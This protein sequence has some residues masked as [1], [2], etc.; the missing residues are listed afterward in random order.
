[1]IWA[2]EMTAS[3]NDFFRRLARRYIEKGLEIV[4]KGSDLVP[5]VRA[6]ISSS[7]FESQ[8]LRNAA[9]SLGISGRRN[10]A[11]M[12]EIESNEIWVHGTGTGTGTGRGTQRHL[13]VVG[14][15]NAAG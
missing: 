15:H 4:L 2:R 1:M 12:V 5:A 11:P 13:K 3:V 14:L 10:D 9:I 6:A 7:D 8:H